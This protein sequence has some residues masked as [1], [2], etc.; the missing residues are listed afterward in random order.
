MW[1]GFLHLMYKNFIRGSVK[2]FR[3]RK[4]S[5]T[6][7]NWETLVTVLWSVTIDW[8]WIDDRIYRRLWYS[9]WLHF[10]IH[11]YTHTH[12]CVHS[13]VFT[14]RF[15]VA[16]SKGGH[17]PSSGFPQY[18]RLQLPDSHSNSS[19]RLNPTSSLICSLTHQLTNQTQL[20]WLLLTALLIT[21]RHGPH[22]NVIP[23]LLC[24]CFRGNMLVYEDVT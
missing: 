5:M 19:Q 15:S 10:T 11:Y 16:V 21:F 4:R 1:S 20:I 17:S 18:L 3:V 7:L 9:E 6:K 23:L 12:N 13:Y 2:T 24:S 14:S 8:V 22:K